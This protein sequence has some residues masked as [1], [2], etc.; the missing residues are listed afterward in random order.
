MPKGIFASIPL[1]LITIFI[2]FSTSGFSEQ[3]HSNSLNQPHSFSQ[4]NSVSTFCTFEVYLNFAGASNCPGPYSVC[5]TGSTYNLNFSAIGDFKVNLKD[6][7]TV[8]I[9]ISNGE[10]Y[11]TITLTPSCASNIIWI[12]MNSSTQNCIC[13]D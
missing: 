2:Y 10:C 13:L 7:E 12:N 6:G 4:E 11:G 3:P 1:L 5:V 9:C 8:T